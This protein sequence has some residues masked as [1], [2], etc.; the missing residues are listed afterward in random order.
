MNAEILSIGTEL[1]LG[2]IVDTN[3]AYLAQ[4]L[5]ELGINLY[6]KTT[7]GDNP[8]RI[9]EAL[10]QALNR[11]DLIITTG[12]LGPT[13]DDLTIET[14]ASCLGEEVVLDQDSLEKIESFFKRIKVEMLESNKKQA[15]RPKNAKIIKN[16]VGTAPGII[17]EKNKKIIISLPGVPREM[18]AMMEETVIPFLK[19]SLGEKNS[20]IK[21]RTLKFLGMG[22]SMVEDKVKDL[23][24]NQTNPT[25]APYAKDTEVHLRITAKG[26]TEEEVNSLIVEMEKKIRDRLGDF[27]YGVDEEL[28][29]ALTAKLLAKKGQTIAL[30]ESCTGG[31]ISHRL[32]NISGISEYLERG[33]VSY[34]NSAK[35]GVLGVKAETL[36]QHG[37]VSWQTAVE[38]AEGV[39][40]A[41]KTNLGLA[42]T[43]IAGPTGGSENK[44]VGL[45]F[46]ALAD[47]QE[48]LWHQFNLT[49]GRI[50]I[51]NRTAQLALRM[52]QNYLEKL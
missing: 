11:A 36:E 8:Q 30:A 51:K 52:L 27:I 2:Q 45:V 17:L 12:G 5:A 39:R 41:S 22:E 10:D 37:A 19:D 49:G 24:L 25:V 42:V 32:T 15:L 14:I 38:M 18:T 4:K 13:T 33:V 44:P 16:P 3:A 46:I 23:M 40:R 48:T 34:S 31:L 26:R 47:N 29:E 1:L 50:N 7:V 21:S 35:M 20:L 9:T 6:F 43:G 28:L